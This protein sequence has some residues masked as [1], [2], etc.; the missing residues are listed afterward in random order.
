MNGDAVQ[1][2]QDMLP[3]EAAAF[4]EVFDVTFDHEFRIGKIA[5][6]ARGVGRQR[7]DTAVDID[8]VVAPV[9]AGVARQFVKRLLAL[10]EIGSERAQPVGALVKGQLAQSRS[11]DLARVLDHRRKIQAGARHARDDTAVHRA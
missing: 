9:G 4:R 11:A 6:A 1:R 2:R 10:A 5:A 3:D 8:R 7:A